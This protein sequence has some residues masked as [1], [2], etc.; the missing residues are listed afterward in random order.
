LTR[1][2]RKCG[3]KGK[4]ELEKKEKLKTGRIIKFQYKPKGR[5]DIKEKNP[6]GS[7]RQGNCTLSGKIGFKAPSIST[8]TKSH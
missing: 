8:I 3:G 1:I 4:V 2:E 7:P 5:P 6:Q